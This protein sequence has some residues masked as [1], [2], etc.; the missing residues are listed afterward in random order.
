M[1]FRKSLVIAQNTFREAIRDRVLYGLV[2]FAVVFILADLFVAKLAMGDAVMV[3]SFGLAGV[4]FF[5]IIITIFLGASLISKEIERRTLYFV[6]AKP[7]SHADLVLGKFIGLFLAITVT[8]ALMSFLYLG[9]VGYEFR[10]FDTLGLFSIV[11]QLAEA[12]LFVALLIFFSSVVRPLTATIS[13]ILLVLAGHL[14]SDMLKN[15]A[16][17]GGA[18]H[19]IILVLY[20]LLPNLE[21]FNVRNLVVHNISIPLAPALLTFAYAAIYIFILLWGATLSL[22]KR[23]L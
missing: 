7:V 10:A 19:K 1:H 15:A 21:K 12:A 23:E 6:L 22:K 8:T 13:A 18:T 4:Y 16:I 2:A 3:K 17:I 5:G 20:Y 14:S 9:V 11:L